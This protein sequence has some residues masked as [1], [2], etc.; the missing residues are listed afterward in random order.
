MQTDVIHGADFAIYIGDADSLV[1]AG[2]FFGFVKGW[3]VGFNSYL[4]EVAHEFP[5]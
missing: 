1:A 4:Y 2:K 5:L 3:E